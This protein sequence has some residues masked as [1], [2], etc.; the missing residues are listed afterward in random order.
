MDFEHILFAEVFSKA[1]SGLP[2]VFCKK[3][4][5]ENTQISQKNT[6]ARV[7]F[8]IKFQDSGL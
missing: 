6:C 3:G 2:E 4:V 1:R 5:I 8:L 7:L